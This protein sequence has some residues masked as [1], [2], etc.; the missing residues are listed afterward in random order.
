MIGSIMFPVN[1]NLS[2]LSYALV[3]VIGSYMYI[4]NEIS[5][6]TLTSFL[7]Y[8]R[9]FSGPVSNLSQQFNGFMMSLAGA[10]RVFDLMDA[11]PEVDD[12]KVTLVNV[13]KDDG[14]LIE[15]D[16]KTN[17]WALKSQTVSL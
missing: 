15:A 10:E 9:Q 11:K 13:I 16:K 3:A 2:Y 5:L 14:K 17:C 4:N 7:L 6:G 12:G 1:V 8:V